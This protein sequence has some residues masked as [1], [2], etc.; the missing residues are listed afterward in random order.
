MV[1][2]LTARATACSRKLAPHVSLGAGTGV[3][4]KLYIA[5]TMQS[6]RSVALLKTR[7]PNPAF[8][9]PGTTIHVSNATAAGRAAYDVTWH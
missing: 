5:I 7:K 1:T 2:F 4:S 9:R 3:G 8:P 6:I